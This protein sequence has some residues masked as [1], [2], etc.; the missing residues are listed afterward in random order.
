MIL[1]IVILVLVTGQRLSELVFARS[2]TARLMAAG[3]HEVGASHY[4]AMVLLHASWLGGLWWFA[5]LQPVIWPILGIYI[6]LQVFRVWT[7]TSIGQRWTTRII[8]VPGEKLVARGPYKYFIHPNYMLVVAEIFC[9][10][11]VFGLWQFA[12]IFSVLNAAMLV[13]R[14]RTENRALLDLR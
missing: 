2:N 6:L 14:I 8:I 13:V 1:Q 3:G 4:P 5:P 7:L 12:A 11:A 9:L 10:P